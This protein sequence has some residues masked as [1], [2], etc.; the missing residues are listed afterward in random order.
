MK[1]I[2]DHFSGHAA[3]Y[4]KFRPT[5]PDALYTYLLTQVRTHHRAWDCATGNGQVARHLA[6]YFTQVEATDIS[7][8]QMDQ[9]PRWPNVRYRVCRAEDTGFAPD[10]FDLITVGQALHWLDTKAFFKEAQRVGKDAALLAVWGYGRLQLS[11]VLDPLVNRFYEETVGPYWDEERKFVT[12]E[13]QNI[14]VPFE[15]VPSPAFTITAS[16]TWSALAGYV[17]T[18]SSVRKYV[19]QQGQNPVP[20][21]IKQLKAVGAEQEPLAVYF[22]VFVRAFRVRK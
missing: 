5:Y 18:W 19:R 17:E 14:H 13:Y 8:P 22:P 20:A 10:S 11:D 3:A 15:E 7:Q 16:W 2:K 6:K 1:E 4:A 21:L 12:H 9:A